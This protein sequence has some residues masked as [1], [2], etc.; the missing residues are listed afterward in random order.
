L[1]R[2]FYPLL[3]LP[4]L[5]GCEANLKDDRVSTTPADSIRPTS[6]AERP[7]R[8]EW[9]IGEDSEMIDTVSTSRFYVRVQRLGPV[10]TVNLDTAPAGTAGRD[11]RFTPADSLKV[12]GLSKMETFTQTCRPTSGEWKPTIAIIADTVTERWGQ[13]QR[14]WRLDTTMVRIAQISTSSVS[15]MI[16]MP[17]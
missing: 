13:P 9:I 8:E 2:N 14:A 15:C 1:S 11:A 4:I 5:L 16:Q 3:L 12:T 10:L 7:W 17:D 6:F